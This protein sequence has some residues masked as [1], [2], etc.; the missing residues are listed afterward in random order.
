M[1]TLS[2]RNKAFN[3]SLPAANE[4]IEEGAV[5][6]TRESSPATF[7]SAQASLSSKSN[8]DINFPTSTYT[9]SVYSNIT[10]A[11][12]LMEDPAITR[13]RQYAVSIKSRPDTGKS[14][15]LSEWPTLP[16]VDPATYTYKGLPAESEME[17]SEQE[18]R[19]A[20]KE[21]A[22]RRRRTEN[23]VQRSTAQSSRA[24]SPVGSQ[25]TELPALPFSSQPMQ[26]LPMTQPDRGA[27][28]S[29][30]RKG[31]KKQRTACF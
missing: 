21:A 30:K 4:D 8:A 11:S 28:G 16:G 14:R 1:V 19:A 20:K 29:R 13:L 31:K 22:R 2:L 27:F 3:P 18:S 25:A 9:P 10:S 24:V 26:E 17:D 7:Y 6:G 5:H 15:I 23:F 12:G